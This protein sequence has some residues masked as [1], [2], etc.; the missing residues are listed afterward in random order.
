MAIFTLPSVPFLNPTGHDRPDAISRCTWL[1][2]VRAPIAPH[3]TRSEMYCGDDHVEV[4]AACGETQ[5]IDV[6]EQA[7]REAQ[8]LV[9]MEASVEVRIVD[10]TLPAD[11]RARLL[12]IDTHDDLERVPERVAHRA[13]SPRVL[14]RGLRVVDRAGSDDD[15]Q[16]IVVGRAGCRADACAPARPCATSPR[17]TG[18]ASHQLGRRAQRLEAV[19]A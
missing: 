13:Q 4:F 14:Q 2:V 10:E 17:Y 5:R 7:A 11:R 8:A 3:A 15:G 1:S 6:A 9:D 16:S 19:D 18:S 12:E